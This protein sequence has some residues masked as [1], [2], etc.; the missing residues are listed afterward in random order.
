MVGLERYH[1]FADIV[2]GMIVV[3]VGDD[4]IG[5]G[6]RYG[7]SARRTPELHSNVKDNFS[8]A[9]LPVFPIRGMDCE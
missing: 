7:F 9:Y 6:P 4:W 3:M 5:E 1:M 2:I 8:L